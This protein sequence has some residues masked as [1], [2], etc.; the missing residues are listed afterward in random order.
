MHLSDNQTSLGIFFEQ[1]SHRVPPCPSGHPLAWIASVL[2]VGD[3]DLLRMVG[4]DGYMLVRY[5]NVCFR[6]S[7]FYTMWGLLVLAP[8][9]SLAPGN[10]VSW[11]KYTLANIPNNPAAN[12]LWVPAVFAYIFSMYF[13]H[14]MYAEYKNFVL[15][16]IQ[17][18]IQG[19]PDTPSQTYYTLMVEKVPTTLRSAPALEAF[20]EKLFPGIFCAIFSENIS[21]KKWASS[22]LAV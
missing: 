5:V 2:A 14:L 4:L 11:N 1:R 12:Q 19:D 17:Y 3:E 18:L 15:K 13:C 10:H 8:V 20:F 22:L 21:A 16:R 6:M 7:V 9:Y